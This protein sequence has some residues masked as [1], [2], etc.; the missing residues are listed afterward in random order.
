MCNILSLSIHFFFSSFIIF[1]LKIFLFKIRTCL[2]SMS[3]NL[4]CEQHAIN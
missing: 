1:S 2:P 4:D 3:L